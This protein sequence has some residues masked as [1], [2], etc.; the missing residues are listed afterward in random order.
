MKKTFAYIFLGLCLFF[1]NP[2]HAYSQEE[3]VPEE[4]PAAA[5]EGGGGGAPGSSD[6]QYSFG[7]LYAFSIGSSSQTEAGD[8]PLLSPLF[9]RLSMEFGF[10]A[11]AMELEFVVIAFDVDAT[12]VSANGI[13]DSLVQFSGQTYSFIFKL[14]GESINYYLGYGFNQFDVSQVTTQKTNYKQSLKTAQDGSQQI[15]GIDFPFSDSVMMHVNHRLITIPVEMTTTENNVV[16]Q[17]TSTNLI[18]PMLI[19]GL[20]YYF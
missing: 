8:D 20:S 6:T 5:P 15:I 7:I 14:E 11:M 13:V 2:L 18:F 19:L 1:Y 4:A 12:G 9:P 3:E 17:E 10:G 16:V